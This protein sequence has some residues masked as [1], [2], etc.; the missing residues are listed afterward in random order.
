VSPTRTT[1]LPA[2]WVKE[3]VAQVGGRKVLGLRLEGRVGV[4][5]G[6]EGWRWARR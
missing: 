3:P 1:A 4:V 6:E 2:Q 5:D